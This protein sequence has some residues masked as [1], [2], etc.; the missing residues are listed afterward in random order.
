MIWIGKASGL[1]G[2]QDPF[3]TLSDA[4]GV[5]PPKLDQK[6]RIK[7]LNQADSNLSENTKCKLEDWFR[8]LPAPFSEWFSKSR[9]DDPLKS[10]PFKAT[11]IQ[12]QWMAFG[13]G[14]RQVGGMPCLGALIEETGR[15]DAN[16]L[17]KFDTQGGALS[18]RFCTLLDDQFARRLSVGAPERD[19]L[20]RT[21]GSA[22]CHIDG[23]DVKKPSLMWIWHCRISLIMDFLCAFEADLLGRGRQEVGSLAELRGLVVHVLPVVESDRLISPCRRL[24]IFWKT[25]IEKVTGHRRSLRQLGLDCMP[26]N[27]DL[28]SKER[29][30]KRWIS[31]REPLP[32]ADSIEEFLSSALPAADSKR[33]RDSL[34]YQFHIAR[35]LEHLIQWVRMEIPD[36][37]EDR[38]VV[39]FE[40]FHHHRAR[41]DDRAKG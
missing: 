31:G 19:L 5:Q 11:A 10:L 30:F 24:W 17:W 37:R 22:N 7:S 27:G 26:G 28:E 32:G 25:V 4:F 8:Q 34:L 1:I 33:D 13:I 18:E 20:R 12:F 40:S 6:T 16:L 9:M 41:F 3:E 36:L 29:H 21:F 35:L 38:L 39:M 2:G 14:A 15:H 23:Q